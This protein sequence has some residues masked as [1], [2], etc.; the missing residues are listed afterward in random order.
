L[1]FEELRRVWNQ[2]HFLKPVQCVNVAP[3]YIVRGTPYLCVAGVVCKQVRSVTRLRL[4]MPTQLE[5]CKQALV[6][7]EKQ[8]T[9]EGPSNFRQCHA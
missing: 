7:A 1:V 5:A 9:L 2:L 8:N 6:R 4:E 3:A